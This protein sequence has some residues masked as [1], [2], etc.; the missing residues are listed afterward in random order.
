[1][2]DVQVGGRPRMPIAPFTPLPVP[3]HRRPSATTPT[4]TRTAPF[5][6]P[7]SMSRPGRTMARPTAWEMS[8][9]A[10]SRLVRTPTPVSYTHLTLPTICSV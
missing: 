10:G 7:H 5:T 9:A 2:G 6:A 8:S 1:M 4:R 3:I